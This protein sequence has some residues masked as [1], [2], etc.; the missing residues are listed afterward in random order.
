MM[1]FSH[2]ALT[3][4]TAL[5]FLS[6][7]ELMNSNDMRSG[8]DS[9]PFKPLT[10]NRRAFGTTEYVKPLQRALFEMVIISFSV[11][12]CDYAM[13]TAI[14]INRESIKMQRQSELSICDNCVRNAKYIGTISAI[15]Q[16]DI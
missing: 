4:C 10:L 13:K 1:P 16:Y 7:C 15:S 14:K 6:L 12:L 9:S 5:L 8:V 11:E 2:T 3:S